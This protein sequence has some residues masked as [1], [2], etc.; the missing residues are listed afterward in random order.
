MFDFILSFIEANPDSVNWTIF[1]L[2]FIESLFIAG[3]FTPATLIVPGVGAIAA[4]VGIS[5][6]EITFY[7]TMGMVVGDSVSYG[8]GILVG[9]RLYDWVPNNYHGYIKQAQ[10]FMEKYGILS[11][12]LGRFFGPL[13]CVVPFT[14]GSLGMN[15]R[16]FFPVTILSAPVWTSL[17]VLSGYF[18]GVAF[19]EYFNYVLIGFILVITIYTVY[20]DPMNLREDKKND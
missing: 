16:I 5:P 12:A 19:V 18:L 1:A 20:K 9:N 3:L 2:I 10:K 14:A 4:T 11:V 15:K 13:R 8:L 6:F 7:A 17:Y